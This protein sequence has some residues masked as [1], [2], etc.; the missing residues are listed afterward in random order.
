LIPQFKK[1]CCLV[2]LF[3]LVL[4]SCGYRFYGSGAFPQDV[5]RIFIEVFENRT[6]K[7]GI[8]RT[9]TNLLISEFTRQRESSLTSNPAEAD[10][11]LKG[12]V[13]IASTRT[14]SYVG[15]EIANEREVTVTIDVKLI[16]KSGEM[17][18]SAKGLRDSQA[19]DVSNSKI[20]NDR[21]EDEAIARISE[22]LSERVFNRLTDSF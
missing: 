1:K 16:K 15:Y 7:T 11:I 10:A 12:V 19:F 4:F 2:Y 20:Q 13:N 21:N 18:W 14:I 3:A 8:E 6:S 17:I 22:R 5:Q 9:V